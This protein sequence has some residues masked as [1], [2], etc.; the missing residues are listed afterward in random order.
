MADLIHPARENP[1]VPAS[2]HDEL[3]AALY[4]LEMELAHALHE[5]DDLK[6][7]ASTFCEWM[8]RDSEKS[9][10]YYD[11]RDELRGLVESSKWVKTLRRAVAWLIGAVAGTIMVAQ[12]IEVWVREHLR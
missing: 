6:E 12:Q 5:I 2:R 1:S 9:Q 8:R 4:K 10:W 3:M 11:N 7:E